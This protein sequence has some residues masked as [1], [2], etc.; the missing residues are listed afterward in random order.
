MVFTMSS[1]GYELTDLSKFTT[2]H[3]N[4]V[5]L[6]NLGIQPWTCHHSQ[7]FFIQIFQL[8]II[9]YF[10]LLFQIA[11][12]MVVEFQH[13]GYFSH[14]SFTFWLICFCFCQCVFHLP[15]FYDRRKCYLW[16][17]DCFVLTCSCLRSYFKQVITFYT[18]L[19]G[20]FFDLF[21][22]AL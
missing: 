13:A 8:L 12:Y 15:I 17:Q 22:F 19:F 5:G 18:L 3:R 9:R 14:A 1:I 11:S 20:L 4:V 6:H 16:H 2:W 10:L 21:R 7:D